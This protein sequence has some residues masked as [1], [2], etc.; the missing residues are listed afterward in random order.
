MSIDFYIYK[1]ERIKKLTPVDVSFEACKLNLSG[2]VLLDKIPKTG[3]V[4]SETA[5]VF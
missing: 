4:L 2:L 5:V 1:S 3:I